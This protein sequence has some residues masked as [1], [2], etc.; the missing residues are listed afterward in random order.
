MEFRYREFTFTAGSRIRCKIKGIS[1]FD[2]VLNF[3]EYKGLGDRIYICHNIRD[4][5]GAI[6][7]NKYGYK[8]SYCFRGYGINGVASSLSY[9]IEDLSP[10]DNIKSNI[11]IDPKISDFLKVINKENLIIVFLSKIGIYDD[12]NRYFMS[13]K[14]G[15]LILKTTPN[16]SE[17]NK[18]KTLEIKFGRFLKA[19]TTRVDK[20]IF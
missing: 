6:C 2:A 8:Y 1:V 20:S 19:F 16:K 12:Y 7:Y 5:A 13:D 3:E 11:F 10:F 17:N 15:F 14:D 4:L 18:E 9:E